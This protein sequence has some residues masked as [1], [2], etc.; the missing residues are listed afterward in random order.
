MEEF[1]P[2]TRRGN[3]PFLHV[4]ELHKAVDVKICGVEVPESR[5][6]CA[7]RTT[8]QPCR[9]LLGL[10]LIRTS[11]THRVETWRMHSAAVFGSG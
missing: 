9:N 11:T 4:H 5:L 1:L 7:I 10:A 3:K 6:H 2:G 8:T